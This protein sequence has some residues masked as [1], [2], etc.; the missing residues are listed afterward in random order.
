MK[1]VFLLTFLLSLAPPF[2]CEAL[3]CG[4]PGPQC[5][6]VSCRASGC[7]GQV[8]VCTCT[9][10]TTG[11]RCAN[12]GTI[13]C[14]NDSYLYYDTDLNNPC[15]PQTKLNV[16]GVVV[17]ERVYLPTCGG[18]FIQNTAGPS[19]QSGTGEHGEE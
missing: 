16:D 6:T 8:S 4:C 13:T 3:A 15:R 1:R 19:A 12:F 14:C 11:Y 17:A 10:P 5:T 2:V 9:G 7:F 18:G